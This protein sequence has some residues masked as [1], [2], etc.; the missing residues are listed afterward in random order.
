MALVAILG[1]GKSFTTNSTKNNSRRHTSMNDIEART[2]AERGGS[3]MMRDEE[4]E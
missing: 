4:Q 3:R 2:G 1:P